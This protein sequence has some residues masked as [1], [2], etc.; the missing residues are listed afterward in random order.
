MDYFTGR[1]DFLRVRMQIGAEKAGN[2]RADDEWPWC[3]AAGN[4]VVFQVFDFA[5]DIV[6]LETKLC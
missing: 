2:E 4:E 5:P 6:V 3:L 1:A